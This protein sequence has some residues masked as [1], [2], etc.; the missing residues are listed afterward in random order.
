MTSGEGLVL[1]RCLLGVV[2]FAMLAGNRGLNP[3]QE[4]GV[5]EPEER[6]VLGPGGERRPGG[7]VSGGRERARDSGAVAASPESG[8]SRPASC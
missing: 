8:A 3:L 2:V 6:R 7:K 1:S 4:E 5:K